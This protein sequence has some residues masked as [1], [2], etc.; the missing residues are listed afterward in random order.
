MGYAHPTKEIQETQH[1][2]SQ[3]QLQLQKSSHF[4]RVITNKVL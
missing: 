2:I 4:I 3:L 1:L